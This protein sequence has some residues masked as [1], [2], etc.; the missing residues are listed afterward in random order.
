[1]T[2]GA[3]VAAAGAFAALAL[4]A[5]LLRWWAAVRRLPAYDRP[6]IT[7]TPWFRPAGLAVLA[8]LGLAGLAA[9]AWAS[10][11]VAAAW[12]LS[13]AAGAGAAAWRRSPARRRAGLVRRI[14]AWERARP[15]EDPV[16]RR[17]GFVLALHPEWGRDFSAQLAADCPDAASL[18]RW[19]V[20][21]EDQARVR[22]RR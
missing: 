11:G 2:P 9:A 5:F 1:M 18:A 16:A 20:R 12:V 6:A 22:P 19:I 4:C 17:Q 3:I 15:G 7:W 8:A 14:G 10:R 13:A 21:V